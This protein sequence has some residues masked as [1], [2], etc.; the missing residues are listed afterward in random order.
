[1]D[2]NVVSNKTTTYTQI[3]V[4]LGLKLEG[5][6][7]GCDNFPLSVTNNSYHSVNHFH[8]TEGDFQ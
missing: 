8:I 3:T 2:N 1:M 7:E 4:N 5:L 6:L